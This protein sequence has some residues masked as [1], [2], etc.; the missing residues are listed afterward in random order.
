MRP[1]KYHALKPRAYG[2]SYLYGDELIALVEDMTADGSSVSVRQ[3][4]YQMVGR[5]NYPNTT[6]KY[7][8]ISKKLGELRISGHISWNAICDRGRG[9][10]RD[11]LLP[12][13]PEDYFAD[14]QDEAQYLKQGGRWSKQ[15]YTPI[16]LVEK[17]ALSGILLPICQEYNAIFLSGH[18]VLSIT[19]L[20]EL[21]DLM[22][23]IDNT[24]Y[25]LHLTDHDGAG[26]FTMP[27]QLTDRGQILDLMGFSVGENWEYKRI[28]LTLAQVKKYGLPPNPARA[29][30]QNHVAARYHAEFG[31]HSWEL[32]ALPKKVLQAMV[33]QAL[34]DMICREDWE[35]AIAD[36]AEFRQAVADG[37]AGLV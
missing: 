19:V 5:Y 22:R 17:D 8:A 35:A 11:R 23:L 29:A 12:Q 3:V 24:P 9:I 14:L 37:L 20:K 13:T 16:I 1:P 33:R 30:E 34:D 18:G 25:I 10:I 27:E 15:D 28:G 36:E 6:E 4:F 2:S 7:E 26:V 32:D 31:P 21:G